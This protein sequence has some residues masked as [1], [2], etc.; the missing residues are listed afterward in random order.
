MSR[1]ALSFW[2]NRAIIRLIMAFRSPPIDLHKHTSLIYG[3]GVFSKEAR[4]KFPMRAKTADGILRYATYPIAGVID[5]GSKEDE[6]GDIALFSSLGDAKEK[7]GADVLILGSAPEGGEFPK[8]WEDDIESA[9][10]A[11]LHVVSGLH[12]PLKSNPRLRKAAKSGNG[13]IWD[14]R[15][16]HDTSDIPLGSSKAYHMEKPIILTVGT[17]AA[18]GKMTVA[19]ELIRAAKETGTKACLIP[20][21]Q[22]AVMI[23]GWGV[24]IDAL[25]ADFMAGAVEKMILEKSEDPPAGEAGYDMLIVEGQGSLYHPAYSNTAIS[26]LHGAVPTHMVLVHRPARKQS[27]GSNLV[28]LPEI[29]DAIEHYEKSVLPDYRGAKVVGIALNTQGMTEDEYL[30]KKESIEKETGLPVG[31]VL[32]EPNFSTQLLNAIK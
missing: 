22:T 32:R 24:A 25:P 2:L 19:Y 8:E 20:T 28:K 15:L 14:V 26:L 16:D 12:Y 29:K 7:T 1:L 23:E 11:G 27:I 10:S 3:E 9:L 17:D 6:A 5:S 18:I 13:T 4:A 21:G 31:D 30:A